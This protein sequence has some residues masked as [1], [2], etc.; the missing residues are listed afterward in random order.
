[1]KLRL[2]LLASCLV[3]LALRAAAAG[4]QSPAPQLLGELAIPDS[5][6]AKLPR[7]AVSGG[8]VYVAANTGRL[9]ASLFARP[10]QGDV[11][12]AAEHLGAAEGHP[13]Y[14][15]ASVATAPD[16]RL[17]YAWINQPQ[18]TIFARVRAPGGA[19]GPART[20]A[21]GSP[22]PVYLTVAATER[23]IVVVWRDPDR[24]VVFSRSG[25]GGATWSA[26]APVSE[27]AGVNAPAIAAGPGGE[28]AVAYTQEEAS[29]LQ[30]FAGIWNGR[31]F[32]VRRVSSTSAD[33]ADPGVAVLPGGRVVVSYRGVAESGGASGVFYAE[34]ASDGGWPVARLIE[35]KVLGPVSAAGDPQGG[36]SLFWV[37]AAQRQ[38]RVW[39]ARRAPG[40][41]WSSLAGAAGASDDTVFNVS[42]AVAAGSDGALYAHA[43]S[44]Y[45]VGNRTVVRAYRF[46]AGAGGPPGAVGARPLIESGAARTR[47][48]RLGV[49]FADIVGAPTEVRW[50]WDAAPTDADSWQ[51][52]AAS[53][54][55]PPPPVDTCGEHTLYTQVRGA[56]AQAQPATD[57]ITLDRAVQ[58]SIRHLTT[59]SAPGSTGAPYA[60]LELDATAD[61]S[62]LSSARLAG[63]AGEV[64][65]A[66][67]VSVIRVDLLAGTSEEGP[68]EIAVELA[69]SIGN[70]RLL[71]TTVIYDRTPP[72]VA[73]G[74]SLTA[75]PDPDATIFQTLRLEG[76]AF[77]DRYSEQPWGLAIAVS[78]GPGVS[79]SAILPILPGDIQRAADGAYTIEA[80]VNLAQLLGSLNLAPGAYSF[81]VSVL[82]A[83][84]NAGVA[85]AETTIVLDVV[86][87]PQVA[88]PLLRR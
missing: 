50:R 88:L 3:L 79:G 81:A 55:V 48:A 20:V 75:R 44:E 12:G 2:A 24:P 9:H 61:C 62:G 32:D 5:A 40:G 46:L 65:L 28:I 41:G 77:E 54:S 37:G 6:Y 1:M 14:S 19:W 59:V 86:T 49:T 68:R 78:A 16:G 27:K 83:A 4:A 11:F 39:H 42:G 51:P 67:A 71:T 63:G 31:S 85:T 25:D 58:A 60:D 22:F 38:S 87:Y 8:D 82:D 36:L 84:G 18:R 21:A 30:V 33:F 7:V 76:V 64:S 17:V 10:A 43:A 74:G 80:E 56:G 47:A 15:T 13:D 26:P 52:F 69:D 72:A 34:R 23:E 29:R 45:F 70:A 66:G 53:I 35:G 73:L 57:T